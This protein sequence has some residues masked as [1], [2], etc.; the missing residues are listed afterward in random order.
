M[1]RYCTQ[2]RVDPQKLR[3][4][5]SQAAPKSGKLRPIVRA[6]QTLEIAMILLLCV[7]AVI[8]IPVG[9]YLLWRSQG[10]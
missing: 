1:C 6:A 4:H 2:K 9:L 7:L 3:V 8:V 10:G 5:L